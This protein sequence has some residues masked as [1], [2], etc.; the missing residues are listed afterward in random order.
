MIVGISFSYFFIS[1]IVTN[2]IARTSFFFA[3][4]FSFLIAAGLAV[5]I[6]I[7]DSSSVAVHK[8]LNQAYSMQVYLVIAL[9]VWLFLYTLVQGLRSWSSK[10][11]KDDDEG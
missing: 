9:V 10:K 1:L 3:G 5:E 4:I 2:K 6:A 8:I 11:N 7:S